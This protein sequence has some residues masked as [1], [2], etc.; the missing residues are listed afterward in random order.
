MA[1]RT[2]ALSVL[3]VVAL[4]L[5]G[6]GGADIVTYI[7]DGGSY[8]S[9]DLTEALRTADLR[10]VASVAP[11]EIAQTRQSALAELRQNGDEAAALAD[12]L[13]SDFPTDVLSVPVH[14]EVAEFEGRSVWLVI[15][16]SADDDGSLTSRRLWV[17]ARDSLDLLAAISGR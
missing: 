7:P 6:C 4:T 10:S 12:V 2:L 5:T 9:E 11:D 15:E 1:V 13:T 16:A 14:I 8:T 3:L 17:F